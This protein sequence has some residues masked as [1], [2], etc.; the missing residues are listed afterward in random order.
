[1]VLWD[2]CA[3]R[4]ALIH[5]LTPRNIFQLENQTPHQITTGAEGDISNLYRFSWYDWCYYRE[6]ATTIF[7]NQQELLGRVLGPSKNEGN[8][9]AQWVLTSKGTVVP[10]RSCRRL[11]A[12]EL[13]SDVEI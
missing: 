11:T 2:Y 9:M 13:V 1:M 5:N 3:Q 4:R 10:R 7:P 12:Q 6:K 8:E